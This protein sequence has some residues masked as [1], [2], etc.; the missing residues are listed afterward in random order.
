MTQKQPSLIDQAHALR[1]A[2]R[3]LVAR[4]MEMVRHVHAALRPLIEHA[5]QHPEVWEQWR[6]ERDAEAELGSCHCLCGFHRGQV[7]VVCAGHA[8]P[9]VTV[10]F[11]SPSVGPTDVRMCHPC[12]SAALERGEKAHA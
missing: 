5:E 9:G 12:A 3:P 1:A 2:L 10:R 11:D 4:Q 7:D 6:R 8:A